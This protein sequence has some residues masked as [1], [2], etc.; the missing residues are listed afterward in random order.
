MSDKNMKIVLSVL[1]GILLVLIASL[2]I[3]K[4][5]NVKTNIN[6]LAIRKGG[7]KHQQ[8]MNNSDFAPM[9]E[10]GFSKIGYDVVISAE[11]NLYPAQDDN[12]G[13]NIYVRANS[14]FRRLNTNQ[15]AVNIVYIT[16]FTSLD[17]KEIDN[18][19]GIATS[20]PAFYSYAMQNNYAVAFVP[21][22]TDTSIFYPNYQEH[23]ERNV[24]FVSDNNQ[25]S[26]V[27]GSA[28]EA[29]LPLEIY[30]YYWIGNIEDQY[31]KGTSISDSELSSYFS[32]AKINLVN[33]SDYE[34]EIGVIPSRVYDIAASKG[35]MLAPYHKEIEV[36][37]G[38]SI[39]M[40]KNAEELGALYDLYINDETARKEKA[41]KA[42]RIAVSEFNVD[43]FVQRINGLIEFLI[44]EK[45]L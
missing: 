28:L 34:R 25:G 6:K 15:N 38:D 10:R 43:T 18:F 31:I 22:F 17:F 23:L 5:D 11:D 3:F 13:V 2:F 39:P 26:I 19:D 7:A 16:D 45:K 33:I 32:S 42:Y 40:Y 1:T 36:I 9:M 37:F 30:G 20:S 27:I 29:N 14:A 24:L 4:T 12:A 44:E 41:E 21:E 8:N 35:F